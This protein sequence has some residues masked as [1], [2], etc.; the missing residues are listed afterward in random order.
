MDRATIWSEGTTVSNGFFA[1]SEGVH[2]FLSAFVGESAFI[3]YRFDLFSE[4]CAC[5]DY[6]LFG[7]E[8]CIRHFDSEQPECGF[9][10]PVSEIDYRGYDVVEPVEGCGAVSAHHP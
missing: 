1:D 9:G 3:E 4:V 8:P 7:F 6:F 2:D 10:Y 5:F